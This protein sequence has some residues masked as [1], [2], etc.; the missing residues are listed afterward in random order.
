MRAQER[1]EILEL[2][3][4]ALPLGADVDLQALAASCHG[5]SGADLAALCR[6]AALHALMANIDLDGPAQQPSGSGAFTPGDDAPHSSHSAPAAA[7]GANG[8]VTLVHA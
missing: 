2:H 8:P 6:E 7:L 1:Q 5:Y 3:S 4:R